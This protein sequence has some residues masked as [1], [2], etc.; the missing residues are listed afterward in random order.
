MRQRLTCASPSSAAPVSMSCHSSMLIDYVFIY[1]IYHKHT[2][3]RAFVHALRFSTVE[4]PNK[5][6]TEQRLS[7]TMPDTS[8]Y[9]M[10]N[11]HYIHFDSGWPLFVTSKSFKILP[12]SLCLIYWWKSSS[13]VWAS[14]TLIVYCWY[15]TLEYWKMTWWVINKWRCQ[16]FNT[17]QQLL[18]MLDIQNTFRVIFEC[19]GCMSK[20][21]Y[22]QSWYYIFF[23]YTQTTFHKSVLSSQ[24]CDTMMLATCR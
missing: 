6:P 20:L 3:C 17:L 22:I 19:T 14:H 15:Y 21:E 18:T 5:L 7:I 8:A 4:R 11:S 9:K 1:Y 24:C 23:W 13:T 12:C 2:G 10:A 16:C